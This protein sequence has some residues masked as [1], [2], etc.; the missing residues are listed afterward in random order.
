MLPT[1]ELHTCCLV[2]HLRGLEHRGWRL[3]EDESRERSS[4]RERC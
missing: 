2:D 1:P 4:G 3:G